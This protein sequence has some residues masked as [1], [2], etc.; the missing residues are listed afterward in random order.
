[1]A[2]VQDQLS[3]SWTTFWRHA[4]LRR[5]HGSFSGSLL[6]S[7]FKTLFLSTF[8]SMLKTVGESCTSSPTTPS[9]SLLERYFFTVNV[10]G[11][12][13]LPYMSNQLHPGPSHARTGRQRRAGRPRSTDFISS[14]TE[15]L[16]CPLCNST[17]ESETSGHK[18]CC[19]PRQCSS[20]GWIFRSLFRSLCFFGGLGFTLPIPLGPVYKVQVSS[21]VRSL[22]SPV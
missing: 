19:V 8:N 2:P 10:R 20:S 7:Y 17:L 11:N 1:M 12:F 21:E 4:P 9:P 3:P 22:M 14:A 6:H 5:S 15:C 18:P 16:L 13:G